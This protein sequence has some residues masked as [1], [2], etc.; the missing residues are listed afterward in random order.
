MDLHYKQEVTVG[1]LVIAAIATFIVGTMW[2]SGKSLRA[3]DQLVQ[4]QFAEV[5]NL[6][7]GNPVKVSGV[8][9]GSVEEITFQEVGKVLVGMKLDPRITPKR[10]AS[11]EIVS[12]GLVGDLMVVFDPGVA[13]EAL[14]PGEVIPGREERALTALGMELGDQAKATLEGMQGMLSP[15]MADELRAT[16]KSFRQLADTYGD[17]RGGP[18]AEL[19][20]ALRS[21]ETLS[22]RLDS[23]LASPAMTRTLAQTDTLTARLAALADQFAGTGA[24]IDSLL[25][26][27]NA[28]TGTAGRVVTDSTLYTNLR[29]LSAS[30]KAFVD[31]LRRNP[32]KITV[33]VKLF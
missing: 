1:A 23:T 24:R 29:D 32:G 30:L 27:V 8:T 26:Q 2:L 31:D 6:K 16:L 18:T 25:A 20:S 22:G 12:V 33:Q 21:L 5:G 15:E 13:S 3:G 4:A 17:T 14:P 28:G 10:D 9:L 19:T 7:V 11:A